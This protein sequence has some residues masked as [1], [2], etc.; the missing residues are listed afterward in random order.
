MPKDRS[1]TDEEL[2]AFEPTGEEGELDLTR[3][4]LT[5][6]EVI[7]RHA[8]MEERKRREAENKEQARLAAEFMAEGLADGIAAAAERG[9]KAAMPDLTEGFFVPGQAA[10]GPQKAVKANSFGKKA[11]YALKTV[12]KVIL[13]IALALLLSLVATLIFN[14]ASNDS[15]TF[16]EALAGL[17]D[18]ILNAWATLSGFV[19]SLFG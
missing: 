16:S 19:S 4:F 10:G 7:R 6:D 5:P 14:M 15:L 12:L 11:L 17:R 18:L 1:L 2:L 8:L 13:A 3:L 9:A